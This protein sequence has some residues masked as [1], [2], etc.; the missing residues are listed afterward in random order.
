[1]KNKTVVKSG[2]DKKFKASKNW[3]LIILFILMGGISLLCEYIFYWIKGYRYYDS[4]LLVSFLLADILLCTC[5]VITTILLP[6]ASHSIYGLSGH[7]LL[8]LR[9]SHKKLTLATQMQTC[10]SSFAWATLF[11]LLHFS[12]ALICLVCLVVCFILFYL[13]QSI[14]LCF[15]KKFMMEK[16][17]R[18][19]DLSI[20]DA[21]NLEERYMVELLTKECMQNAKSGQTNYLVSDLTLLLY[22]YTHTEKLQI[23]QLIDTKLEYLTCEFLPFLPLQLINNEILKKLEDLNNAEYT[24]LVL[25]ITQKLLQSFEI[26][27]H[28]ELKNQTIFQT[29]YTLFRP[30]TDKTYLESLSSTLLSCETLIEN[31]KKLSQEQK[32]YWIETFYQT[33]TQFSYLPETLKSLNFTCLMSVV[34]KKIATSSTQYVDL[35]LNSLQQNEKDN[36]NMTMYVIACV[37]VLL[38]AYH[39]K[40]HLSTFKDWLVTLPTTRY[41][42]WSDLE[43]HLTLSQGAYLKYYEKIMEQITLIANNLSESTFVTYANEFFLYYWILQVDKD[44]S[45]R[46]DKMENKE[47]VLTNMIYVIEYT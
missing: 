8:K 15:D 11:T 31:N 37:H 12:Y 17:Q 32:E 39:K 26:C 42:M 16:V 38:Y 28:N 14:R 29:L 18:L 22:L 6:K 1:M 36:K 46:Y 24:K 10:L 45:I 44:Y 20:Y 13:Y 4:T 41:G 21:C 30:I 23:K 47:I 40:Y 5:F 35:L 25:L 43:N 7:D 3:Q 33:L 9:T 34:L 2:K 27:D 19:V